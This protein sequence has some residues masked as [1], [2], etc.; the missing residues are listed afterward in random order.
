MK[1]YQKRYG[2]RKSARRF[3]KTVKSFNLAARRAGHS[4]KQIIN[5]FD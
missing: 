3:N 1:K 2:G 5:R 4:D